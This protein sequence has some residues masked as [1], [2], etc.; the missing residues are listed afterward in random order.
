M[1]TVEPSGREKKRASSPKRKAW[2]LTGLEDGLFK[3]TCSTH[4]KQEHTQN[5][6]EVVLVDTTH[7][8]MLLPENNITMTPIFLSTDNLTSIFVRLVMWLNLTMC[9]ITQMSICLCL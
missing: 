2:Y 4:T 6:N 8:Q 9:I 1:V 3:R 7:R 5:H